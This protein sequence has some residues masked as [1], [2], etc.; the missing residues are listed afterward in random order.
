[1]TTIL[2]VYRGDSIASA[3]LIA[4]TSNP[5]IVEDVATRL[6]CEPESR[7]DEEN[8]PDIALMHLERGRRQALRRILEEASRGA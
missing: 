2:A 6:L 5:D 1:M 7:D 8:T 4:A 3:R